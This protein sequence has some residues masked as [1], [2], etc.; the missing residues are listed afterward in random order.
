MANGQGAEMALP[1]FGKFMRAVYNDA[2]LQYS[3]ASQFVFP[4]YISLCDGYVSE[5]PQAE[6]TTMDDD[7][8]D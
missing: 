2:S 4:P 1:I 5:E 3:Q 8:F 6:E 7:V